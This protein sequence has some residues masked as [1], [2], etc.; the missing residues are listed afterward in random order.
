MALS[1][2]LQRGSQALEISVHLYIE[3]IQHIHCSIEIY[4]IYL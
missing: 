2:K 1:L 4:S 3:I